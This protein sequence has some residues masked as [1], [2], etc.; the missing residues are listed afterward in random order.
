MVGLPTHGGPALLW[1]ALRQ[2]EGPLPYL[3]LPP[4]RDAAPGEA[5]RAAVRAVLDAD[6]APPARPGRR[7]PRVPSL[8]RRLFNQRP[9]ERRTFYAGALYD[10]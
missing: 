9:R 10:V 5:W 4:D 8:A 7:V 2:A 6:L 3:A 1:R